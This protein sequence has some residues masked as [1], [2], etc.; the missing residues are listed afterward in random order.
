MKRIASLALPLFGLYGAQISADVITWN[1]T[2]GFWDVAANW[3]TGVPGATDDAVI[4]PLGTRT[5]TVR[6]TGSP[7]VVNAITMAGDDTLAM[8]GGS[9]A[10]NGPSTLAN[11]SHSTGVLGGS[12]DIVINGTA[13]L[14]LS[15]LTSMMTGP[16][17]TTL[18]GVTTIGG[19]AL[20]N[21]RVL[22]NENAVT[23]TGG[24]QL[25]RSNDSGSAR[26]DNAAGAVFDIKSFNTSIS[27]SA[28]ADVDARPGFPAF[29]NAGTLSRSSN[30]TYGIAVPVLNSGLIQLNQGNL[31]L[32]AGG[33]HSGAATM[34]AGTVL[35]L[36]G[37]RHDIV[38]GASFS[39]AGT[40]QVGGS[41]VIDFAVP[42]VV[43]SRFTHTTGIIQGS[44][45]TLKGPTT[46]ALSNLTSMMTGPATTTLQGATAI[47][48]YA[49][50]NGRI[51]RNEGE[52]TL[53]GGIELNRINDGGAGRI[54]NAAGALFDIRTFNTGI[55]ANGFADIGLRAG[56]PAF[57]NQGLLR[58][59]T[60]GTYSIGVTLNNLGTIELAAGNLTLTGASTNSGANLLAAGTTLGLAAS[61]HTINAGASFVGDGRVALAGAGTVLHLNAATTIASG[62]A[63]TGGTIE[64]QD[65]DLLGPVS[66]AISSSL[67]VMSGGGTTR[68]KGTSLITGGANNPFGLDSKRILQNE[69]DAVITGVIDMNRLNT[70]GLGSG[71]LVNTASGVI[72]IQ[73][74]NQGIKATNWGPL[75]SG[76]D[77]LIDNAGVFKK[78]STGTYSIGVNFHNTGTVS[79]EAGTLLFT[80]L[81]GNAGTVALR[82][83]AHLGV[84]SAS[85]V[86]AGSI[87]GNG[88]IDL[89]GGAELINDGTLAPGL[90]AGALTVNGNF[91][92][93][94]AG[95]LQVELGSTSSFDTLAV[96]G[97]ATLGGTLE[98]LSLGGFSPAIGDSFTVM[99]FD[100]GFGDASDSLGSFA[101]FEWQGFAPGIGFTLSYFDHA[102]VVNAV[103]A[104]IPLPAAGW[105]VLP[106]LACLWL[107]RRPAV[108]RPRCAS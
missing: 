59:S 108:T 105:L 63:M 54:D 86:N 52:V 32:S 1:D 40:L 20:D 87:V 27:A 41:A 88:A 16:A 55:T 92:Q 13:Q 4:N 67:G 43:E 19:Y 89:S 91:T 56:F 107:R 11:F 104:P 94:A 2:S 8:G 78:T 38:A 60:A 58:R 39:G 35:T 85:L 53:T 76:A 30:G 69:G 83:N 5:V 62:F 18:R 64:G 106:S 90:S 29:N 37:G 66:L 17:T 15:N 70:P 99:T 34:A 44:D 45:L 26:I 10:V 102:V 100:D 65:L 24:I 48:G 77:A 73:T 57:N 25:N 96:N 3:S 23:L 75:D 80:A 61:T 49:I 46:L 28:L 36:G 9:L 21:G 68:L 12:G 71:K 72:D 50:D 103:A 93:S 81:S 33:T 82:N 97:N 14:S 79:V 101:A 47:A 51:L 7:F 6:A 98:L 31:N 84:S 95:I 74:F 22:R 42:S